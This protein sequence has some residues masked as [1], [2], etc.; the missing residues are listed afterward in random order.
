MSNILKE[1]IKKLPDVSGVYFFK[2]GN[3]ILYIGKATSLQD[4]VKSY[5]SSDIAFSRS[6]LIENMVKE[7]SSVDWI[8]TDSVLEALILESNLIKKHKPKYNT[9]EKDD[10]SFNFVVITEEDYP[11]VFTMRGKDIGENLKTKKYKLKNIFG[12]YTSGGSLKEAL[13]IVRKIFPFRAENEFV[14]ISKIRRSKLNEEIG[15]SPKFSQGFSQ[16]EYS[17]N[18]RNIKLFFEGKKKDIV[19]G[20]EK[21]MKKLS[22]EMKFEDAEVIKRQIFSLGHIND[23]ALIKEQKVSTPTG[24]RIE[25]YDVAHISGLSRVGVMVVMGDGEFLKSDYRKFNIKNETGGDTGALAEILE[26]R[27]DH[28][29]WKL[30]KLIVVDGGKAQKNF[31][32]KILSKYGYQIPVVAVTKG[33]GHK[34]KTILGAREIISKKEQ[35]IILSNNEAHRFALKYHKEKRGKL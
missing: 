21:E 24:F 2:K 10:K 26:R 17:R 27:L 5:F 16:K 22:K 6:L 31:A 18:I 20:L 25:A 4:R 34:P 3:K 15:L 1:K 19:K 23:F 11:R 9:K 7:A 8:E 29:E 33:F 14:G 12:P 32:E 28:P 35:D 30:P 13:K